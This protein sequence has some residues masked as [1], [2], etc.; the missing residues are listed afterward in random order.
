[1]EKYDGG[2]CRPRKEKMIYI[3]SYGVNM[4]TVGLKPTQKWHIIGRSNGRWTLKRHNVVVSFN[5]DEF[6]KWFYRTDK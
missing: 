3:H 5:T 2:L 1:M 4:C 6:I